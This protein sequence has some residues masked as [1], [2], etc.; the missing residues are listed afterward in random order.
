MYKSDYAKKFNLDCF[1]DDLEDNLYEMHQS[2]HR[3]R[4]GLLLMSQPWNEEL[5]MDATK[6]IRVHGWGDIFRCLQMRNRLR[7]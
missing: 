1:V 5:I 7:E 6:Y 3:W 2:K 4:K